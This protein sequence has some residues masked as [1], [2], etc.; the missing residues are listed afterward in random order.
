MSYQKTDIKNENLDPTLP[1]GQ[2]FT[3]NSKGLH[4]CLLTGSNSSA[5]SGLKIA[6]KNPR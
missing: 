2:F 3:K 5:I 1:N 6:P 4:F